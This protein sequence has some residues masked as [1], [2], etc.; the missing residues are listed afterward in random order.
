MT[1]RYKKEISLSRSFFHFPHQKA[2]I[3]T[4]ASTQASLRSLAHIFHPSIHIIDRSPRRVRQERTTSGCP[5]KTMKVV[6]HYEDND[7]TALHK[8]L[9]ITLPKS[10][11]TGPTSRLLSQFVESYNGS[12]TLGTENPLDENDLHLAIRQ[13]NAATADET[14]PL[15]PLA[16]DAVIVDVI[17]DREDVYVM[18][19]ASQTLAEK[20][21]AEKAER[22]RIKRELETTTQCTH[23]GCKK[24]FPRGGPYPECQYHAAP[25]V[26][27]ETA[28]FWSC[29]PTKKAY[30]WNDFENIPGCQH[31]TCSEVKEEQKQFLGGSDLR[32]NAGEQAKLKSIDDFNKAEAAG[33]SEAAPVLDQ[34]RT[35]MAKLGVEKELYDQVLDGLKREL[36]GT[37]SN[38]A[39]LLEAV[40]VELGQKLKST[41]KGI[42]AEQQRI[43]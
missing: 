2:K 7:N 22:E 14:K 15:V 18:H 5:S 30:D 3:V 25:P 27:H 28:K 42:A 13:S 32:E 21:E 19:G 11:K 24:R 36:S 23:F 26:F 38:E 29:C 41:M 20:V 16:S 9:R 8:S 1:D 4:Q 37:A 10:W 39:E 33:G 35:V 12:E 43:T 6:L 40:A 17:A 31:G 34:L